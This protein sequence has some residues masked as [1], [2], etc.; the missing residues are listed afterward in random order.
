MVLLFC[1]GCP[2]RTAIWVIPGSTAVHLEFGISDRLGS[3]TG[4]EFGYIRVNRC[5]GPDYGPTGANWMLSENGVGTFY[6]NRVVYGEVPLGY[7]SEQGPTKLSPGCYRAFTG[8]SGRIEFT[9]NADGAIS[10]DSKRR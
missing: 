2:R 5:D 9:V 4:V 7:Q 3:T 8:G 1:L 10:E 6:V